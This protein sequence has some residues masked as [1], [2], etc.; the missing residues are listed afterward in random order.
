MILPS[1]FLWHVFLAVW[2]LEVD[3]GDALHRGLTVPFYIDS[4]H[5]AWNYAMTGCS[6]TMRFIFLFRRSVVFSGFPA[7]EVLDVRTTS[8]TRIGA[9]IAPSATSCCATYSYSMPLRSSFVAVPVV[10]QPAIA[11]IWSTVA[12]H[13]QVISIV[14]LCCALRR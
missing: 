2:Y 4:L 1:V 11:S 8:I 3:P 12:E 10:L 5:V 13:I 7:C 14:L 6:L 9:C